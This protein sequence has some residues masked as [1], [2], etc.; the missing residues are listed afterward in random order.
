MS[1]RYHVGAHSLQLWPAGF[2]SVSLGCKANEAQVGMVII[3]VGRVVNQEAS[4]GKDLQAQPRI[5]RQAIFHAP[6]SSS[7]LH[8]RERFPLNENNGQF[9]APEYMVQGRAVGADSLSN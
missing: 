8:A 4:H 1:R 5:Q 6:I 9:R 2:E 3:L 7:D